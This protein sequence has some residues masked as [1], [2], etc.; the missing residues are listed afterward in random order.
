MYVYLNINHTQQSIFYTSSWRLVSTQ[1]MSHHQAT[2]KNNKN[3][4]FCT[5]WEED[6]PLYIKYII[7]LTTV[8]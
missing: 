4:K 2:N 6:L 8:E 1:K 5:S 7:Q 3:G